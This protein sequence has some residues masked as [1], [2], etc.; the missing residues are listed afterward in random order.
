MKRAI[1]S[2]VA[3]LSLSACN[4]S[5]VFTLYRNSV[6][7]AD[8]RIHI[9]SFDARENESYNRENCELARDLFA[10]QPDVKARF[11]CEKGRYRN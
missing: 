10:K 6:L 8:A 7:S 4:D 3:V 9:A 1:L 11:W 2:L 5:T